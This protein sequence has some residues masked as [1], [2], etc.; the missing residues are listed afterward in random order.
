MTLDAAALRLAALVESFDD[1]IIRGTLDGTIETWNRPAERLFGYTGE[2][3]IGRPLQLLVPPERQQEH[4]EVMARIRRGERTEPFDT[5]RLRKGGGLVEISLSV[6]PIRTE[7]GEIIGVSTVARDITQR[8]RAEREALR[9]AAIV[10]SS[11]DAIVGKDLSGTITSW[12]RAAERM[13]GYTAEEVIGRSITVIIPPE[14]LAEEDY[15]LGKVRAGVG[16]EHFETVR[17][18]K[19]GTLID[20]SL[21]VS[22]IIDTEGR[23]VGASKIARDI[24]ERKQLLRQVEEASRLK[25]EFLATLSHELRTPL[26][27]IMGYVYMLREGTIPEE[28]RA[29]ALDLID[30]N[31][32]TLTRLVGDVLDMSTIVA[33]KARLTLQRCDLV[34]VLDAAVDVVR[35][36][37]EAK[38]LTLERDLGQEPVPVL[39][40]PDR[41][42]QVFWNLLAN[43]TK[44]TPEGGRVAVRLDKDGSN[45]TASIIDTGVGIPAN[46]LPHVFQRFRQGNARVDREFSGLGLGLALVRHFVEL[47]GGDVKATSEGPG[48]GA[49]FVVSLPLLSSGSSP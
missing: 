40:D 41:L 12:N 38:R 30:R 23:I 11:D 16:I 43:A 32:K 28:G 29:R 37:M 36:T 45:A 4:V 31:A 1:A 47:H 49:T 39:G 9:L 22:P 21:T 18:R 34:S 15:V 24:S 17:R 33:G 25:D 2:E 19:D 26:N 5:V 10:T 27:A 14:R 3:A 8:K 48:N 6:S 35:P 44:F 46:F 42:Q 20:I 7:E 13:F